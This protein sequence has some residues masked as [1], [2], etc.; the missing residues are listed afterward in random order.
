MNGGDEVTRGPRST[1]SIR[2]RKALSMQAALA[3]QSSLPVT[4]DDAFERRAWH[5]HHAP[6]IESVTSQSRPWLIWFLII[7]LSAGIGAT[8]FWSEISISRDGSEQAVG[9]DS[10]WRGVIRQQRP[11][12][13]TASELSLTP[14]A[15]QAAKPL[16]TV[17]TVSPSIIGT[18][19]ELP[20]RAAR[21][22]SRLNAQHD[23]V[24][25][26]V[27]QVS[28]VQ[29]ASLV[30]RAASSQP[31]GALGDPTVLSIQ[32]LL[33]KNGFA[34]G[35]AD[36]LMGTRTRT[37]ILA[38][39]LQQGLTT[40]GQASKLVLEQLLDPSKAK[41]AADRIPIGQLPGP[42]R[43][44][45]EAWCTTG[46][47]AGNLVAYYECM[48]EELAKLTDGLR[49]PDLQRQASGG[50]A[51]LATARLLCNDQA[52]TAPQTYFKCLHAKLGEEKP[53]LVME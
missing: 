39:Q 36:G 51:A 26:P 3:S 15:S 37:A 27:Q 8:V 34:P 5:H 24:K 25:S 44:I 12:R 32:G 49:M 42:E 29:Q 45:I 2:V 7:L 9:S 14:P 50:L 46:R 23:P 52:T 6:E 48:G 21:D 47:N 10:A 40:N 41:A 31:Q 38:W 19:P 33:A 17:A 18:A 53:L 4:P 11:E 1:G 43:E 22:S 30:Q 16:A 35:P 20:D 13:V 28:P